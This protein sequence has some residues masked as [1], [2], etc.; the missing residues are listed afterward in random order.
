MKIKAQSLVVKLFSWHLQP[1]LRGHR[2]NKDTH[3]ILLLAAIKQTMF[4]HQLHRFAPRSG[5][6]LS[7][8]GNL[9]QFLTSSPFCTKALLQLPGKNS[10][11]AL[12][13]LV[14][15]S[16]VSC[17]SSVANQMDGR[18]F[19]WNP[20]CLGELIREA[21]SLS[22]HVRDIKGDCCTFEENY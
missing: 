14:S 11:T 1:A 18:N 19:G 21:S 6:R 12:S 3:R 2:W 15:C 13:P 7:D 22:R 20:D 16:I 17:T 9:R 10:K 5:L 4:F 8:C